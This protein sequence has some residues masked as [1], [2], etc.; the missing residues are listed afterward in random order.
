[1][2][3]NLL[4][5]CP[6]QGLFEE[7]RV[8]P[9]ESAVSLEFAYLRVYIPTYATDYRKDVQTI[10]TRYLLDILTNRKEI[11]AWQLVLPGTEF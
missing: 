1:M 4:E 11:K 5:R 7:A 6:E 10:S 9:T 3:W 2:L 8:L